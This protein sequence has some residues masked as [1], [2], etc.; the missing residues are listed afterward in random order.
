MKPNKPNIY[1]FSELSTFLKAFCD[2]KKTINTRWSLGLWAKKLN[3]T[4][5]GTLS[6]F[7]A[8]RRIPSAKTLDLIKKDISL[9]EYETEYFDALVIISSKNVDVLLKKAARQLI[10]KKLVGRKYLEMSEED[11]K[12]ISSSL[13]MILKESVKLKNFKMDPFWIKKKLLL[14]DVDTTQIAGVLNTLA[15]SGLLGEEKE[16]YKTPID[17]NSELLKSYYEEAL[18]F[19]RKAV[20]AIP[21]EDRHLNSITFCCDINR[22][23]ELKTAIHDFSRQILEEFD[24][25]EGSVVYQLHTQ[26]VPHIKL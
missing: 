7:I 1:E 24:Q 13:A 19:N 15:N 22:L 2:Y 26:L 9:S 11:F 10:A 4:G 3:V 8:G 5:S 21:R 18:D 23:A 6:N 14:H 12:I 17:I 25:K 20:R 16:H